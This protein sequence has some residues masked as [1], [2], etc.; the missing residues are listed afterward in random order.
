MVQM[1]I[2]VE[3]SKNIPV[4]MFWRKVFK[5]SI[6]FIEN[7]KGRINME[8]NFGKIYENSLKM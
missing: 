2:S 6:C 5:L 8:Q 7:N 4:A 3:N 1:N